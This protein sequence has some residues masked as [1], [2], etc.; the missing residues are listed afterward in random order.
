MSLVYDFDVLLKYP[1]ALLSFKYRSGRGKVF[2]S[3]EVNVEGWKPMKRL[4]GHES[5]ESGLSTCVYICTQQLPDVTD[6][7]W[8]PEDRY[9]ASVG[10]DSVVLVWCGYTLGELYFHSHLHRPQLSVYFTLQ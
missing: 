7:A 8:A 4:P 3:N 5:G 2:G 6:L 1:F 9:L 10:L